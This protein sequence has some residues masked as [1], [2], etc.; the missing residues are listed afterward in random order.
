[1]GCGGTAWDGCAEL[2]AGAV[3][4]AGEFGNVLCGVVWVEVW[5]MHERPGARQASRSAARDER[6]VE[7]V[8]RRFYRFRAAGGLAGVGEEPREAS[9]SCCRR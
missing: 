4:C 7:T 6:G 5:A 1:M 2:P 8:T 9:R 3:V